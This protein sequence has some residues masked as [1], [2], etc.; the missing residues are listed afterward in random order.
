MRVQFTSATGYNHRCSMNI[1]LSRE[2]TE[3]VERKV[4]A[5]DYTNADDVIQ[6][7]LQLLRELE[8]QDRAALEELRRKI[9]AGVTEADR[10]ELEDVDDGIMDRIRTAGRKILS[11]G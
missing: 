8:D 2:L 5:G 7:S 4:K 3:F 10:G 9:H 1:S 6:E 11:D